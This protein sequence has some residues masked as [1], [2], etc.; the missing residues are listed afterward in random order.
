MKWYRRPELMIGVSRALQALATPLIAFLVTRADEFTNR[1][2]PISFCN[3]LFVGN[4]CAALVV[5]ASFGAGGIRADWK[6]LSLGVRAEALLFGALSA[7]L[8][9]LIYTALMTTMVTNAILLARLGPLLYA[10]VTALLLGQALQRFEWAGYGFIVFGVFATILGTNGLHLS[11]G[12]LLIIFSSFVYAAVTLI[13]KRLLRHMKLETIVFTRNCVSSLVFFV[14]ANVLFGPHHFG[15]AFSGH[16]W[17]IMLVYSAI[18]IVAAQLLWYYA[19]ARTSPSTVAQWTVLSPAIAI[20][21]AFVLNGEQPSV[22]QLF[23]LAL[24]SI[25]VL[26]A[27]VGKL[28]PKTL[29]SSP[30]A[31]VGAS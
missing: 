1:A 18:V 10:V 20:F 27:N 26:I 5:L 22:A 2:D 4:T 31:S 21:Y 3:V 24:V 23:A 30:E 15:D 14:I 28:L 8:S 7:L 25:G 16:L 11:Q 9:A 19:I 29:S 13:S 17:V 12:D 6:R